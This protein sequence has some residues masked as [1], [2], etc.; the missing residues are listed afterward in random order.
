MMAASALQ[1]VQLL[2]AATP[3]RHPL[4]MHVLEA[5]VAHAEQCALAADLAVLLAACA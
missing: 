3:A 5:L 2:V 1:V 4:A